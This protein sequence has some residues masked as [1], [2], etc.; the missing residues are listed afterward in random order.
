MAKCPKEKT[1]TTKICGTGTN[2]MPAGAKCLGPEC[3]KYQ[4][5]KI[6]KAWDSEVIAPYVK[7]WI[8]DENKQQSVMTVGNMS[9]PEF[10]HRAVI[11]SFQYGS[12]NGIGARI[13]I[14]DEEG[15]VFKKFFDKLLLKMSDVEEK[16]TVNCEWGWVGSKCG[17]NGGG[18]CVIARTKQEHTL[19]LIKVDVKFD[20]V[21]KF[22][23]ECTDMIQPLMETKVSKVYGSDS[24]KIKLRDAIKQLGEDHKIKIT[25][26]RRERDGTLVCDPDKFFH[27]EDKIKCKWSGNNQNIVAVIH[28]WIR[29]FRTSR[30]KGI[31]VKWNDA[32]SG[33][34]NLMIWEDGHPGCNETVDCAGGGVS[35]LGTYIVNGGDCSPVIEFNPQIKAIWS[36]VANA[37]GDTSKSS[38]KTGKGDEDDDCDM[39]AKFGPARAGSPTYNVESEEAQCV[40]GKDAM[41]QTKKSDRAHHRANVNFLPFRGELRIQG[42]P[43]LDDP[44]ELAYARAGII[45]INPFHLA[46]RQSGEGSCPEWFSGGAQ[47]NQGVGGI[48]QSTC[49]PVLSNKCWEVFGVSHEIRLGAYTTTLNCFLPLPG[50]NISK[51]QPLGGCPDGAKV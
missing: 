38:G 23:L 27:M 13:E 26:V 43:T 14:V 18:D 24:N 50:V 12:D 15:G 31:K 11:S 32:A 10:Q 2:F 37:G 21:Y 41:K 45:V 33:K 47:P 34:P 19:L 17:D 42:D 7:I 8:K 30:H 49:N 3:S 29:P 5:G 20:K 48:A 35:H 28:R 51:D 4:C 36:P 25:Y 1:P 6:R 44:F 16:Y 40:Y 22:V 9:A 46:S 39:G